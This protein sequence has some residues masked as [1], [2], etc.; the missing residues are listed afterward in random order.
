MTTVPPDK[1]IT[2]VADTEYLKELPRGPMRVIWWLLTGILLLV[3]ISLVWWYR[4]LH[5]VT[6][7][8]TQ[9]LRP[10]IETNREPESTNAYA[11]TETLSALSTSIELSA[12]QA[13][14]ESTDLQSLQTDIAI[15]ESELERAF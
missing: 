7:P 10:T 4:A 2:S 15:I 14:L 6:E 11:S 13:D 9:P 3:F 1:K 12:I 5:T 8:T